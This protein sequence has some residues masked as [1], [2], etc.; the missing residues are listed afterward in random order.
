MSEN[1]GNLSTRRARPAQSSV[2]GTRIRRPD[3]VAVANRL[4]AALDEEGDRLSAVVR[5]VADAVG[6]PAAIVWRLEG[7][8]LLLTH[9]HGDAAL[10]DEAAAGT[11]TD[12]DRLDGAGAPGLPLELRLDTRETGGIVHLHGRPFAVLVLGTATFALGPVASGRLPRRD[13]GALAELAPM[14]EGV[15]AEA[16]RSTARDAE[17]TAL[18]AEVEMGR[19]ALGSTIDEDRSFGLLLDLAIASSGARGGLVATRADGRMAIV[20]ERDLPE[21]FDRLDLTP[22][23]GILAEVPGIPGLLIVEGDEELSRLGLDG[24]LAVGG[25]ADAETADLVFGLIPDGEEPLPVDCAHLLETIVEQAGLV[26]LS[27]RAARDTADRHLAALRGLCRA[28]DAR[29]A[30]S[31]GHHDLVATTAGDIARRMGL[32]VAECQ[33]IA[34]AALVHDV[35]ML[36][37]DSTLA[38]EF[39]HPTL[40][41]DMASLVPGAASLAPLIRAHHEWFDGFGFPTGLVGEAIPLGARVLGAAELYAETLQFWGGESDPARVLEEIQARRG[42]QLDPRCADAIVSMLKEGT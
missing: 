15:V 3:P 6:V 24:L 37:A 21:G 5:A 9:R 36:A 42:T 39:L 20:A 18:R 38:A 40:G 31:A 10:A 33:E 17:L 35:G 14:V 19:R 7:S 27:S 22:G 13:Q 11:L 12:G 23:A 34:A 32:S 8:R 41:A 28:L 29:S 2:A 30:A 26:L 1:L 16:L 25:P 4:F